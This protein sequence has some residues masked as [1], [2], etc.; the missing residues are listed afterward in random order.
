[1][2]G[3]FAQAQQRAAMFDGS[4]AAQARD[5]ARRDS[6]WGAWIM[7]PS[8][9]VCSQVYFGRDAEEALQALIDAV[10]S[11]APDLWRRSQSH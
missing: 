11:N 10:D 1:M 3:K 6:D 8:Y 9:G 2:Q 7:V 4:A 5:P